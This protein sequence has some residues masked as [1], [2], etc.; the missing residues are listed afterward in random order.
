MYVHTIS[1][2]NR[3]I[4]NVKKAIFG[5][6]QCET[7]G[8]GTGADVCQF[9]DSQVKLVPTSLLS[10]SLHYHITTTRE[11]QVCR[12]YCVRTIVADYAVDE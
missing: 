1:S 7:V 9:S 8:K 10:R 4:D 5:V 11:K 6:Q 3:K 12:N 2:K